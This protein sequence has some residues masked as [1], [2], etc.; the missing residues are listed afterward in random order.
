M[1]TFQTVLD[2]CH[3]G[4]ICALYAQGL[5]PNHSL[6]SIADLCRCAVG[7]GSEN[8]PIAE[9]PELGPAASMFRAEFFPSEPW[10]R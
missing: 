8:V 4:A 3:A 1:S 7:D 2:P 6:R 5:T 9:D 10:S